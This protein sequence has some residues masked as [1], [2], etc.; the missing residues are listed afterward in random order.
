M[1]LIRLVIGL[2]GTVLMAGGYF[3]SQVAYHSG[4]A[5]RYIE[6]VDSSPIPMLSLG[7]LAAVVV[8]AFFKEPEDRQEE[9]Q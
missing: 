3:A 4:T 5:P 1:K 8:L 7:L 9:L 6:A 2:V